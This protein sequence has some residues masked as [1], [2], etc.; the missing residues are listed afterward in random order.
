MCIIR[1]PSYLEI[2]L[3]TDWPENRQIGI[4]FIDRIAKESDNEQ[5]SV[6]LSLSLFVC[7]LLFELQFWSKEESL[8]AQGV[9]L[10]VCNLDA[11]DLLLISKGTILV[12]MENDIFLKR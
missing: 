1:H 2:K 9:C 8:P 12:P 4:L 10:G 5:G 6:H 3:L 7:A 11:V